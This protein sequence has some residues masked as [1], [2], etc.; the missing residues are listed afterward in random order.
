MAG[1]SFMDL[2]F[3]EALAAGLAREAQ[4]RR[5]AEKPPENFFILPRDPQAWRQIQVA[6]KK[7]NMVIAVEITDNINENC[8]RIQSVFIQ[9]ARKYDSIPFL[10]AS[11]GLG[12]TF[13]EVNQC[14]SL[15]FTL[16]VR[17]VH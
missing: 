13:D 10:R 8:K 16:R 9:L 1:I 4:A 14:I 6:S 5:E 17:F 3:A 7:E 12:C 11:I 15:L 2:L